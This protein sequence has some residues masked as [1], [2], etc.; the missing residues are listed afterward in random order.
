MDVAEL[1][2]MVSYLIC[3][4]GAT[5]QSPTLA[6]PAAGG[7]P[8]LH[9]CSPT[10]PTFSSSSS[11]ASA[12][13]LG[14][15]AAFRRTSPPVRAQEQSVAAAHDVSNSDNHARKRVRHES[16]TSATHGMGIDLLLNASTISDKI[17]DYS[18]RPSSPMVSERGSWQESR[19]LPRLPPISQLEGPRD[20]EH[21]TRQDMPL[22]LPSPGFSSQSLP[23]PADSFTMGSVGTSS[24]NAYKL[25]GTSARGGSGPGSHLQH[26]P[27]PIST[28]RS[29]PGICQN[30]SPPESN[31]SSPN[32]ISP[33]D[34]MHHRN[35]NHNHSSS[36]PSRAGLLQ[37]P[38][39][40]ATPLPPTGDSVVCSDIS[41]LHHYPDAPATPSMHPSQPV[42]IQ[43]QQQQ[44]QQSPPQTR[45]HA[46]FSFHQAPVLH[47]GPPTSPRNLY[48]QA[49]GY[50][51]H[52]IH[53]PPHSGPAPMHLQH[54]VSV[55][56][57]MTQPPQ[58]HHQVHNPDPVPA[59]R[60]VSKPKFNYAF[61]DTKRPRGPSSRW[62]PEEDELLKHAVKQF[63]EDRQW[64][65]VAQQVPGRSNLQ[66]RQRWL[67]NI[68]AQVEKERNAAASSSTSSS[69]AK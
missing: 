24:L 42:Y 56:G 23:L 14:T 67:C 38:S 7:P 5:T 9:F 34:M 58:Q 31:H 55:H 61:L 52:Q 48:M 54:A 12:S 21:R 43:Q 3:N 19:Q 11:Y 22:S 39:L 26:F 51:S 27:P 66:C 40:D 15:S 37:I 2:Q 57:H 69:G 32:G 17:D 68:K 60:N 64:V 36:Y 18:R 50:F 62:T 59:A 25:S 53:P 8:G 30:P 41:R 1:R 63:G 46:G 47:H 65:K 45:R 10:S 4:R 35:H 49:Q 29:Q 13:S 33:A 20:G 6:S 16:D 28:T 44:N